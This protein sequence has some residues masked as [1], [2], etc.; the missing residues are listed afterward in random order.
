MRLSDIKGEQALDVLA[1]LLEP[2]VSLAKD[3]ELNELLTKDRTE[4]AK[5]ALKMHKHEVIT[6]M[7]VLDGET[8]EEYVKKIS[9]LTLPVRLVELFNDP[10]LVE[11]FQSQGQS[12][13]QT[14]SGSATV[15]TEVEEK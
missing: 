11:L 8:P 2:I 15:N 3:S 13:D 5:V 4:A 9:L 1:D 12:T 7:A 6:I 10:E 14:S